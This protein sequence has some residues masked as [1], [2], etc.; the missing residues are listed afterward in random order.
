MQLQKILK[1]K[2]KYKCY[3]N[4]CR[5]TNA[6]IYMCALCSPR[7]RQDK[8]ALQTLNKDANTYGNEIQMQKIQLE[9]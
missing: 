9:I 2:Q 5:N 1:Y 3:I 8:C 7:F 4:A 6:K